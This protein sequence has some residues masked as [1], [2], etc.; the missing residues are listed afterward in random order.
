MVQQI[1]N[2]IKISVQTH[3]EGTFYKEEI[4]HFAFSYEVSISNERQN[5][6]QLLSR[7]WHISDALNSKESVEG[8]GVVGEQPIIQPSESYS[9]S[10]G[11]TLKSPFGSMKGLYSMV[12]LLDN[13]MFKAKIPTFK[14]CTEFAQN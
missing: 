12:D 8:D 2:G 5:P 4:I 11:C 14:L 13:N 7:V 9:Y 6:V 1:T 10:S 3:F